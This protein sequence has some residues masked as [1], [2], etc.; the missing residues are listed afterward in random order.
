MTP[1]PELASYLVTEATPEELSGQWAAIEP[2][3]ARRP[4]SPW[5][6]PLSLAFV[7]A[8]ALLFLVRTPERTWTSQATPL[9][10]ALDDGSHLQ[11]RPDSRVKIGR[12]SC[13]ERV[14]QYV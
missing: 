4:R 7:G 2:R 14:C 9:T 13:R 8:T 11:L 1:K 5:S 6:L 10:L 12:A 3:L